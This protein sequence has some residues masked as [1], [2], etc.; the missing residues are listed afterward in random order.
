MTMRS[1]SSPSPCPGH[2]RVFYYD[3]I[4]HERL[5]QW[6]M[7]EKR[8]RKAL[9]LSPD[10]P[11]VLNYLGYSMI[12]KKINLHRSHGHGEEGRRAEAQ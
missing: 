2:W 5:K 11:S 9:E 6:D 7:A 8:F 4:A 3:G 10:E 1:R 12:E